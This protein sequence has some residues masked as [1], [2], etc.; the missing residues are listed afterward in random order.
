MYPSLDSEVSNSSGSTGVSF[1]YPQSL[2]KDDVPMV[3]FHMDL[4]E[5]E[6]VFAILGKIAQ[7]S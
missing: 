2:L 7:S 1:I 3:R 4:G 6:R 5:S